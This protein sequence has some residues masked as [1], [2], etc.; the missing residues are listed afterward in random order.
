[1][2]LFRLCLV[3]ALLWASSCSDVLGPGSQETVTDASEVVVDV[4]VVNYPALIDVR[5]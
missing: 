3:A 5:K 1:M 4:S 2:K